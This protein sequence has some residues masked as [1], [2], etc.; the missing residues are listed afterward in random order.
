MRISLTERQEAW[1]KAEAEKYG[2]D[3]LCENSRTGSAY[4]TVY[5]ESDG[6][7]EAVVRIRM[8]GH[9]MGRDWNGC[10]D[11]LFNVTGTKQ[12]CLEAAKEIFAREIAKYIACRES[13]K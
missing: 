5:D 1:F 13:A 4:I 8:S 6:Y 11:E 10:H 12:F 9:A 7:Q 2:F 3:C